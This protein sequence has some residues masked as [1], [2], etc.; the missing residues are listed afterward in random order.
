[1]KDRFLPI[2]T[3][4]MLKGGTKPVMIT[5]FCIYPAKYQMRET[6]PEEEKKLF[7]YGG[8]VYPE[9]ILTSEISLAFEH[10]QIEEILYMG[11]ETEE[12]KKFSKLLNENYDNFIKKNN[13]SDLDSLNED[14]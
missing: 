9:G 10:S 12:H 14:K 11:Y 3:V 7:E 4:V 13:K 5:S 6:E 1:M 2:G 8:C